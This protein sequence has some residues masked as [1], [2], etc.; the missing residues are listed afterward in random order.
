MPSGQVANPNAATELPSYN[1]TVSLE[2]GGAVLSESSFILS[3]SIPMSVMSRPEI[4]MP[5]Y[6]TSGDSLNLRVTSFAAFEKMYLEFSLEHFSIRGF[7]EVGG[8]QM[9]P[10]TLSFRHEGIIPADSNSGPT[11]YVLDGIEYQISI[12]SS[13]IPQ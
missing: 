11:T 12:S 10:K 6:N 1:V 13:K 3:P 7:S 2:Q 4:S 9:V 5:G 8:G